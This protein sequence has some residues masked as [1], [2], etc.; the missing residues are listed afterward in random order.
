[1]S[2]K[3]TTNRVR[4]V[5]ERKLLLNNHEALGGNRAWWWEDLDTKEVSQEFDSEESALIHMQDENL[6]WSRLSDLG[7]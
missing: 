2:R 6:R 5:S 4:L 1:M 3:E 7:D